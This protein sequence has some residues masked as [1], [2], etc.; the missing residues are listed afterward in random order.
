M[1][2]ELKCDNAILAS[3]FGCIVGKQLTLNDLQNLG[4]LVLNH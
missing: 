1:K 3:G 4:V 2:Q